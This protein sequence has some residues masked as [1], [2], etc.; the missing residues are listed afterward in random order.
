MESSWKK[1]L[2]TILSD[3]YNKLIKSYY[4]L[5]K[6]FQDNNIKNSQLEKGEGLNHS[7]YHQ[8]ELFISLINKIVIDIK[9]YGLFP[10]NRE[11]FNDYIQSQLLNIDNQTPLED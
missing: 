11:E 6:M 3:D 10:E 5:R 9:K 4:D 8:R 2:H 1:F 7:M